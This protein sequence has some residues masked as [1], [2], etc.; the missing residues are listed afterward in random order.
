MQTMKKASQFSNKGLSDIFQE[1]ALCDKV[2]PGFRAFVT[3]LASW[4]WLVLVESL[5]T[6]LEWVYPSQD[7]SLYCCPGDFFRL[8]SDA[9]PYQ[10]GS[11][12]FEG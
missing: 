10:M 4:V 3:E 1:A 7:F 11:A 8:E 6:C 12:R 9:L 5:Y 2:L